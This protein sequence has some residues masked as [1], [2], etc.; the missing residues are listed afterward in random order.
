[1]LK[2]FFNCVDNFSCSLGIR[3]GLNE[4][5]DSISCFHINIRNYTGSFFHVSCWQSYSQQKLTNFYFG[6]L[7]QGDLQDYQPQVNKH[8]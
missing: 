2:T 3:F 1:M 8:G 6:S 5:P 7:R 4:R